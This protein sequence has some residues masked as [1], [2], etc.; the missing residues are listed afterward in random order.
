MRGTEAG[1]TV[2]PELT[3]LMTRQTI[4]AGTLDNTPPNLAGWIA[5]P[6]A[7]KPGTNMPAPGLS[8]QEVTDIT[9]YLETLR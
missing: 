9:A 5:N 8:G 7:I 1:G 3:H 2:A 6:Q 4:A